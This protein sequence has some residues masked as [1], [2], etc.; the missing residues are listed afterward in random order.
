M[1]KTL[2]KHVIIQSSQSNNRYLHLYKENPILP[3]ALRFLGDYSFD[4]QTRFQ[5][6]PDTSDSGLIHIRSL[7]NNKYW[8]NFGTGHNWV[9]AMA[10]KPVENKSDKNCT[11]FQPIFVYSDNNRVLRLRHVNTGKMVTFYHG[12]GDYFALLSLMNSNNLGYDVCTFI[13]WETVTVLPDL[14]RIKNEEN[15]NYL[16][17][18]GQRSM[19]DPNGVMIFLSE[20]DIDNPSLFEYKVYPSRDGGIRLHSAQYDTYWTDMDANEWVWLQ[21]VSNTNVDDTNTVF[22]PTIIGGNRVIIRCLKNNLVCKRYTY[23]DRYDT[24]A[25]LA[26]YPDDSS[27]MVIEE[28]VLSRKIDN[29][30]YHLT[31]ARLYNEKTVALISDDSSNKTQYPLESKLNLKTTVTNT[32]CWSTSVSFTVGVNMSITFGIPFIES[33]ELEISAE[34]TTSYNWG[35]TQSESLE[36]GSEKAITLPPM[37]RIKGTLVAT[38]LS[39]DIPFSY[40]QYDVLTDGTTKV[41]EKN[42]GIFVGNNG[43]G[44]M[45]DVV[46]LPLA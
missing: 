13:D 34:S 3:N 27:Y 15:G 46:E 1:A 4:P 17:T 10:V 42:D 37:T 28:P 23:Y 19:A 11:L 43:Y 18:F 21:K 8:A 6:E 39:Y 22:L 24:L 33:G 7:Q 26:T 20:A 9:G 44:Y 16:C 25:T 12:S 29:V 41:T 45:Y 38:R 30:R 35:E 5:V 40:T 2:P 14:I 31:D 32:T 36:V